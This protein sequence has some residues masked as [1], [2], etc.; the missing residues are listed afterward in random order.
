MPQ[1]NCTQR[2]KPA[3]F[4]V[5]T[6]RVDASGEMT[7]DL[8]DRCPLAATSPRREVCCRIMND[9]NRHRKAGP[10]Y[11]L[12]VV[13]CRAHGVAFTLYPPGFAPFRRQSVAQVGPDGAR[14]GTDES[15]ALKANFSGTLFDVALDATHGGDWGRQSESDLPDPWSSSQ[16]RHLDLASRIVGIANGVMD[17]T[18]EA[19]A[20]SLGLDLLAIRERKRAALGEKETSRARGNRACGQA[21]CSILARLRGVTFAAVALLRCGHWIAQ[22]GEP[23]HWDS[24]RRQYDRDPFPV[25]RTSLP[26]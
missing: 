25:P 13:R 21:I 10:G 7:P 20:S 4:V 9:H 24:K 18:Q 19:I 15:C 12:R 16:G 3:P 2:A 1:L 11:P 26:T 17:R 22:W 23:L 14:M 5:T 8:P 6:Y